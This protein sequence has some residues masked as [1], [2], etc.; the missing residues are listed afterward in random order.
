VSLLKSITIMPA[1]SSWGGL[2]AGAPSLTEEAR[3]FRMQLRLPTDRPVIMSGH[4]AAFW[5]MGIAAKWLGLAA[6]GSKL[7]AH[8]AW[9]VVDHDPEDFSLIRVP[10]VT[11]DAVEVVS[12]PL[13]PVPVAESI[14]AGVPPCLIPAFEPRGAD[15]AQTLAER[16][17]NTLGDARQA[18]SAARTSATGLNAAEQIG[19]ATSELMDHWVGSATRP[20]TML[21]VTDLHRTDLFA[22]M[23]ARMS[24]SLE[25]AVACTTAYNLAIAAAPKA[26]LAPLVCEVAKGRVELPLWC[27]DPTTGIR[28]RVFHHTLPTMRAGTL[29]PR[30]LLLTGLM[31]LAACDLFIHGL[32]GGTTVAVPGAAAGTE[33][34]STA[35]VAGYDAAAEA[36][37]RTWL[38][39]ELR[40]S[41]VISATALLDLGA[42][43]VVTP[44]EAAS[45][46]WMAQRVRHDPQLLGDSKAAAAKAELVRT[47][48]E[49][50]P[51]TLERAA[52]FRQL[53]MLL[54]EYQTRHAAEIG[55]MK[56]NAERL[57]RLAAV[58]GPRTD[59]TYSFVLHGPAGLRQLAARFDETFSGG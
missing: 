49:L 58:S 18:L 21:A 2:L 24:E 5:H 44:H 35:E 28:K 37:F 14:R 36:W 3:R 55:E 12:V 38:G 32:G 25:A 39:Q 4:Q 17:R 42:G 40:P 30:A 15:A 20:G 57:S 9:L 23:V 48:R 13:A 27:L 33:Q 10:V 26:R 51:R 52:A 45:A 19:L 22:A 46:A 7:R 34:P 59:R 53:Q 1:A 50:T 11:G 47:I 16:F 29:A 41:V 31:R 6:A 56:A 43:E 8:T 54:A